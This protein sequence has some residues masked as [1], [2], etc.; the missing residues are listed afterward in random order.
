MN[1]STALLLIDFQKG[2]DAPS[3]G[4]RN[5]PQA[6]ERAAELLGHWRK[7]GWPVLH[8][9]HLS[10]EAGSA[11]AAGQP[12]AAFKDATG[13]VD[14]EQQFQKSVNSAFIGTQLTEYLRAHAIDALV[15]AGLTTDHCV[16]TSTRMAGN[17]GFDVTLVSDAT[18]TF[19]RTGPDG[20]HHTADAIHQ[21]HLASLNEEFCAVRTTAEVLGG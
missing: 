13:P 2:F 3:W 4:Q 10:Q 17:L 8:V 15:I 7:H 9:Q 6:E 1:A 12:G 21:V 14:G 16:S 5:N 11:L 19:D 18:A 20:V